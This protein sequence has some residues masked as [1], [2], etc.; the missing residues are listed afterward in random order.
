[1][2][3]LPKSSGIPWGKNSDSS[4]SEYECQQDGQPDQLSHGVEED[5]SSVRSTKFGKTGNELANW[6]ALPLFQR[7]MFSR[8]LLRLNPKRKTGPMQPYK[9]RHEPL[10]PTRTVDTFLK[11]LVPTYLSIDI[12]GRLW[13]KIDHTQH[14]DFPRRT[15]LDI[16]DETFRHGID[17]GVLCARGSWFPA[18]SSKEMSGLLLRPTFA[19]ASEDVMGLALRRRCVAI[20]RTFKTD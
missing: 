13:L 18:E 1:M 15:T 16:E 3:F 10:Q 5:E 8:H 20:R 14:P 17:N 11:E 19:A 6:P 9:G 7:V 2:G 4:S 12:D